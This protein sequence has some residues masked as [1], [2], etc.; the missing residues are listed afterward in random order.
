[1][2]LTP[3]FNDIKATIWNTLKDELTNRAEYEA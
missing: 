3:E 2:R 1:M